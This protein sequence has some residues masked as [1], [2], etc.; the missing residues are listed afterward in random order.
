MIIHQE[1]IASMSSN[2]SGVRPF[3]AEPCAQLSVVS[4]FHVRPKDL[5][6]F[7]YQFFTMSTLSMLSCHSICISTF[8]HSFV[9]SSLLFTTLN[10]LHHDNAPSIPFSIKFSSNDIFLPWTSFMSHSHTYGRIAFTT[11]A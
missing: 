4:L 7:S 9:R 11:N 3:S 1:F 8:S 2:P 6:P 10:L 5:T